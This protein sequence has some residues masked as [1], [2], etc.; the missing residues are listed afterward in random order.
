M[1]DQPLTLGSLVHALCSA[2]SESAPAFL[3]Q[4]NPGD[5]TVAARC[6]G[7]VV[8]LLAGPEPA[9]AAARDLRVRAALAAETEEVCQGILGRPLFVVIVPGPEAARGPA[10]AIEIPRTQAVLRLDATGSVSVL[11]TA[12]DAPA[13]PRDHVV[14]L[15][16]EVAQKPR[17]DPPGSLSG[18]EREGEAAMG[19]EG[20]FDR[21]LAS[22][23]GVLAIIATNVVMFGLELRWD[24]GDAMAN[25]TRLGAMHGHWFTTRDWWRC[26]SAAYLHANVVHIF[27][28]LS[29]LASCGPPLEAA[30][31]TARFFLLY[32]TIAVGSSVAVAF[33]DPELLMVGASGAI[34][35]VAAALATLH[36]M[37]SRRL[38]PISGR[39]QAAAAGS[40]L[41]QTLIISFLPNVSGVAHAAGAILGAIL[42]LS[43]LPQ[44]GLAP[45][46]PGPDESDRL[47]RTSRGLAL[48]C[49]IATLATLITA[50]REGRAWDLVRDPELV[51]IQLPWGGL[52][53]GVPSTVARH[54][55]W[56]SESGRFSIQMGCIRTDALE[57]S[58]QD[59][60]ETLDD[61]DVRAAMA[62]LGAELTQ[63]DSRPTCVSL[64]ERSAAVVVRTVGPVTWKRYVVGV[65]GRR[66]AVAIYLR[67]GLQHWQSVPDRVVASLRRN[68]TGP[69]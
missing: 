30:L 40:L 33:H 53:V 52:S 63:Q 13:A 17:R 43:Q 37:G 14:A 16:V 48:W 56:R 18:A 32:T 34:L 1:T 36:A 35:G 67:H 21:R 47:R 26:L 23:P 60:S 58:I 2:G 20:H 24:G 38:P 3:I 57:V 11:E 42:I 19:L 50:V 10:P 55:T 51:T 49:V 68:R 39:R 62:A 66:V 46:G 64:G 61:R 59:S 25:L 4:N 5:A 6:C 22:H 54:C 31:G 8:V 9:D 65:A 28:N 69:K 27:L 41:V 12:D 45:L 29:V 44:I 7:E 15:L